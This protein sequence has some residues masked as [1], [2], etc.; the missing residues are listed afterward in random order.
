MRSHA[1]A[2]ADQKHNWNSTFALRL[3]SMLRPVMRSSSAALAAIG[4]G[5]GPFIVANPRNLDGRCS[6][7]VG[8][9]PRVHLNARQHW[10]RGFER[11]TATSLEWRRRSSGP[12]LVRHALSRVETKGR[13]ENVCAAHGVRNRR[14]PG[15]GRPSRKDHDDL[16]QHHVLQFDGL[17]SE[18]F[19]DWAGSFGRDGRCAQ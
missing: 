1:P 9:L 8:N 5:N 17:T 6:L 4:I 11:K 13:L 16:H 15:H 19:R 10:P 14:V 3:P 7:L 12:A 2:L 18:E